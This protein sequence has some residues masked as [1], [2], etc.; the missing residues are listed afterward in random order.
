[1][2]KIERIELPV[3]FP[4]GVTNCYFIPDSIPTL[5]DTGINTPEA[6][7]S[8]RGGLKKFGAEMADIGR[9][10]LTHG[11]SDHAGSAGGVSAAC[12]ATVF[13]HG[14]D[15]WWALAG[16]E[17]VRSGYEGELRDF[18]R[19]TGVPAE[20]LEERTAQML[21]RFKQYFT[22]T[23]KIEWLK[24]GE[25]FSFDR[26]ALKVLHTPG[27]TAGSISLLDETDRLLLSGDTLIKG[28]VPYICAD[29]KSPDDLPPYYGFSQYERSLDLLDALPLQSVLP[30]HGEPFSN[31]RKQI[32][33][34]RRHRENRKT[35]ILE[36]FA[37]RKRLGSAT[38]GMSQ[39][40]VAKRL[41]SGAFSGGAFF[42]VLS[43]VRGC[44][45]AMEKDGLLSV[46]IENE[47]RL[48]YLNR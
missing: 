34:C 28:V 19:K 46:K 2:A 5:I 14:H 20:A 7:Q 16:C 23:S 22:A 38:L 18:F 31:H 26:F 47:K 8:L 13:V 39:Y 12:K 10:I 35:K 33:R 25:L 3:P 36:I 29:L 4:P 15:K 45:E 17:D 11:H 32:E 24:G 1:M 43:E 41:F 30:G 37:S 48:Y 44:M 21:N 6:F 9:I 27:H 42:M 40:E